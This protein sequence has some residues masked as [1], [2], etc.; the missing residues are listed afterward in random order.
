[1]NALTGSSAPQQ[2]V[3][4]ITTT[5]AHG[6]NHSQNLTITVNGA[7]EAPVLD[8]DE[9]TVSEGALLTVSAAEGLLG[10]SNNDGSNGDIPNDAWHADGG[11]TDVNADGNTGNV[12]W[13]KE[14]VGSSIKLSSSLGTLIVNADGSYTFKSNPDS[15][16]ANVNDL[17]FKYEATNDK[18]LTAESTLTIDITDVTHA[19]KTASVTTDDAALNTLTTVLTLSAD[20]GTFDQN[21][22]PTSNNGTFSV[23]ADGKTLYF[24]QTKAFDGHTVQGAD[25]IASLANN[26]FE[27]SVIGPNGNTYTVEVTVKIVDDAPVVS[28][29][30]NNYLPETDGNLNTSLAEVDENGVARALIEFN[31]GA[32]ADGSTIVISAG[33]TKNLGV[34]W[35]ADNQTWDVITGDDWLT[36]AEVKGNATEGFTIRLGDVTYTQQIGAD[37]K[38]TDTWEVSY[39]VSGRT[40]IETTFTDGDKDEVKHTV[41]AGNSPPTVAS[42]DTHVSEVYLADGTGAGKA[43]QNIDGVES[44]PDQT[45]ATGSITAK[46]LNGDDLSFEWDLTAGKQPDLWTSEG[47]K[48]E[49]SI[50]KDNSNKLIGTA[51]G[52]EIITIT[53]T[54]STTTNGEFTYEVELKESVHHDDPDNSASD[55]NTDFEGD[56]SEPIEPTEGKDNSDLNFGFNIS[57]GSTS[58]EGSINVQIQDDILEIKHSNFT[59]KVNTVETNFA[60]LLTDDFSS[61]LSADKSELVINGLTFTAG[62][63]DNGEFGSPGKSKLLTHYEKNEDVKGLGIS[64]KNGGDGGAQIDKTGNEYEA[65]QIELSEGQTS[66]SLTFTLVE[67]NGGA[68]PTVILYK[69][70]VALD[71]NLYELDNFNANEFKVIV[72]DGASFDKIVIAT[73]G[74]GADDFVV[75]SVNFI[76]NTTTTSSTLD[77]K[78]ADGL[79]DLDVSI[80][81]Q[82]LDSTID[83]ETTT[84]TYKD[85]K[86]TV[87][88]TLIVDQSKTPIEWKFTPSTG[89][90]A[91]TEITFTATDKDGDMTS[92]K[93][94]LDAKTLTVDESEMAEG[95]TPNAD[96]STA[97]GTLDIANAKTITIDGTEYTVKEVNGET[98]DVDNGTLSFKVSGNTLT[99]TYK[100]DEAVKHTNPNSD[101]ESVNLPGK[102]VVTVTDNSGNANMTTIGFEVK[103]DGPVADA[104]GTGELDMVL[105]DGAEVAKGL[106][107][108]E[109]GADST[110]ATI[111]LQEYDENNNPIG[112]PITLNIADA[113]D[114]KLTFGDVTLTKSNVEGDWNVT[115]NNIPDGKTENYKFTITDGD[116][117][118]ASLDVFA[119]NTENENDIITNP[120]VGVIGTLEPGTDY[121][122]CIL[123]DAS[124]SMG[125]KDT[126]GITR[127]ENA[128]NALDGYLDTLGDYSQN[129]LGGEINLNIITFGKSAIEYDVK[130]GEYT[131]EANE[132]VTGWYVEN[133]VDGDGKTDSY[134]DAIE[135]IRNDGTTWGTN[136]EE[137]L[138]KA[139]AWYDTEE[140]NGY[141][142]KFIFVADGASTYYDVDNGYN[143]NDKNINIDDDG[144][145]SKVTFEL[146][147]IF[148]IEGKALYD[149]Y[150]ESNGLIPDGANYAILEDT[151]LGKYFTTTINGVEYILTVYDTNKGS[152]PDDPTRYQLLIQV[153]KDGVNYEDPNAFETNWGT[154]TNKGVFVGADAVH[155]S[156]FFFSNNKNL[157]SEEII[158]HVDNILGHIVDQDNDFTAVG[159]DP[160]FAE[161]PEN[162]DLIDKDGL[163]DKDNYDGNDLVVTEGSYWGVVGDLGEM[164]ADGKLSLKPITIGV[165]D[166]GAGDDLMLGGT[167]MDELKKAAGYGADDYLSAQNILNYIEKNEALIAEQTKTENPLEDTDHDAL[168]GG[169]GDDKIFGQGGKDLLIGDGSLGNGV[170]IEYEKD[171]NGLDTETIKSVTDTD[172]SND[173][174]YNLAKELGIV[175]PERYTEAGLINPNNEWVELDEDGKINLEVYTAELV[176][177][178]VDSLKDD[179]GDIIGTQLD[180]LIIATNAMQGAVD[181]GDDLIYGGYGDDIVIG[182]GGN[183]TLYG[184]DGDDILIGGNGNDTLIGGAGNDILFAGSGENVLTGGEGAD[185]FV[186]T[187]DSFKNGSDTITDLD[188]LDKIDLS[189]FENDDYT[190]TLR[191][192]SIIIT[193]DAETDEFTIVVESP[194]EGFKLE[195]YID[196]DGDNL[197][198]S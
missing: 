121:N 36:N 158:D 108:L 128:L 115:I 161:N 45:K 8:A 80:N 186:F 65:V 76:T 188:S 104:K 9:N 3:F 150:L 46:D 22:L 2:E 138:E 1:M 18:G 162:S 129:T 114:G 34:E 10:D 185:V 101:N 85:D 92:T 52:K 4:E 157:V 56:P 183:D 14:I 194:M 125:A 17:V 105:V 86:G 44:F 43:G 19:N 107:T 74:N 64:N 51:D 197:I 102:V 41:E 61:G 5:D 123:L 71:I 37:G 15:I 78:T 77:I 130:Y 165:R 38:P 181:G 143:L 149:D 120:N 169:L 113:V 13:T 116:N 171:E 48:V 25:D 179:S 79:A 57:D 75:E 136:Y 178:L 134:T 172:Q 103:D 174:L 11:I 166:A 190:V 12:V 152:T 59:T 33:G 54:E 96:G 7:D 118:T 58:T 29:S 49:W 147:K 84:Y 148:G 94:V 141:T 31:H 163:F 198:I 69:D 117:D 60:E 66:S 42:T 55:H 35:D 110:N 182:L 145:N 26:P 98:I 151:I 192:D 73:N 189:A 124:Q 109:T 170:V 81:G 99:Y 133:D 195:D 127:F 20:E 155:N 156:N 16:T 40:D 87:L 28:T 126:N 137:A 184:N 131:N 160:E 53:V 159:I 187:V 91:E 176:E 6:A 154:V 97:S 83:G 93:F 177:E 173:D 135:A 180:K 95:T 191:D 196:Y 21:D 32:D 39:E 72:S 142:N 90:D 119:T 50:D 23:S 122:L 62:I 111:T 153:K 89:Y 140:G 175:N 88:G 82:T 47:D 167:S 70:G 24:T 100:Q 139:N 30:V 146:D 63:L 144:K 67:W 27:V 132:T 164:Q 68:S 168:L 106:I 112:E 193:K